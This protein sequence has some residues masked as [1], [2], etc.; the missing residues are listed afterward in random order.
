MAIISTSAT[1]GDTWSNVISPENISNLLF[2]L[3]QEPQYSADR[4]ELVFTFGEEQVTFTAA[5]TFAPSTLGGTV[6]GFASGDTVASGIAVSL[7]DVLTL[8]RAGDVDGINAAL[9]GAADTINGGASEDTLRGFGGG[10]TLFGNDGADVLMGDGGADKL[11]GGTGGD[12]LLGGTGGDRLYGQSGNDRLNGGSGNDL[13][14]GGTGTDRLIGGTGADTFVWNTITELSPVNST[15]AF[16]PD[17]VLDFNN[18]A[19]D[20]LDISGIDANTGVLGNQA[21]TFIGGAAFSAAGQIRSLFTPV[22]GMYRLEFNTD[23][24]AQAEGA[25]LVVTGTVFPSAADF[26]L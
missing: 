9:W 23:G 2:D 8:I 10:D 25:L 26:I 15:G 16:V 13:I 1:K 7:F 3:S 5:T 22:E 4:T 11:Y 14:N 18:S 24:D 19:G 20:R 17:L 12:I 21:F 6:A